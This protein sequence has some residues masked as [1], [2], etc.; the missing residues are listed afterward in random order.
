[1]VNFTRDE[2]IE[3]EL[4]TIHLPGQSEPTI[5]KI[6]CTPITSQA[7][8][9]VQVVIHCS[10]E[11]D[12]KIGQLDKDGNVIT[13]DKE[14]WEF[15]AFQDHETLLD[16]K[17]QLLPDGRLIIYIQIYSQINSPALVSTAIRQ[18]QQ[19]EQQ[20]PAA[21]NIYKDL[22]DQFV[23]IGGSVLL[24]FDDGEQQCHTFPLAVR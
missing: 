19:Q 21:E 13:W 20:Q 4:L 14:A 3:T 6:T 8:T 2:V 15:A 16:N 18:Q 11:A 5:F 22:V 12:I 9:M 24:V 1:M 23:D 10:G 17:D 7:T